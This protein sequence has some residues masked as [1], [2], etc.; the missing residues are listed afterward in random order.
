MYAFNYQRPASL[1]AAIAALAKVDDAKT[2][3][4]GTR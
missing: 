1:R 4:G 3:R 2:T